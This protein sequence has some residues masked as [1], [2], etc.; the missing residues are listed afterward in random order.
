M[1]PFDEL[2]QPELDG[3]PESVSK[4]FDRVSKTSKIVSHN[5]SSAVYA[6]GGFPQ[7]EKLEN[8]PEDERM[9]ILIFD[10]KYSGSNQV[11]VKGNK[12][13]CIGC[14]KTF[15]RN[16][17]AQ[18]HWKFHCDGNTDRKTEGCLFCEKQ[19]VRKDVRDR[20][21]KSMHGERRADK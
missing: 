19:L 12:W 8:F 3:A 13:S 10:T 1:V 14:E 6:I 7:G 16:S 18:R 20:H 9:L 4:I 21:L 15:T 17:N 11:A 5:N 2:R